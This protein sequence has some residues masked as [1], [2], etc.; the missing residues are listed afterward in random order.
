MKKVYIYTLSDPCTGEIKYIGKTIN[1]LK[2]RLY[3]HMHESKKS[4][5]HKSNWIKSLLSKNLKPTIEIL[6]IVNDDDWEF[7][8]QYWI[9]QLKYWGIN[10]TNCMDGGKGISSEFM[11]KNNPMFNLNTVEKMRNS[12]KGNQ[13]AKG[14]KHSIET[15]MKVGKKVKERY[16]NNPMTEEHKNKIANSNSKTKANPIYQYNIDGS[17]IKK[18]ESVRSAVAELKFSRYG[19]YDCASGKQKLYKGFI[20]SWS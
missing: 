3:G 16:K 4:N 19:I 18:Y 5:T 11:K 15:R 8:E 2:I 14:F 17:L 9:E 7:W 1:E 10:L 20:W 6:D 13:H 12:M